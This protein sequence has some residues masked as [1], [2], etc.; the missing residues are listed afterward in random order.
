MV[1]V[2]V[3]EGVNDITDKTLGKK[4]SEIVDGSG[5][6]IKKENEVIELSSGADNK[7]TMIGENGR[8]LV[9]IAD[10]ATR[11]RAIITELANLI[12]DE[13][14]LPAKYIERT[15][16]GIFGYVVKSPV[17]VMPVGNPDAPKSLSLYD[18]GMLDLVLIFEQAEPIDE[19]EIKELEEYNEI[20]RNEN[21]K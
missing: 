17:N 11:V 18:L 14:V 2:K 3:F 7:K 4:T 20:L 6:E 5:N 21:K 16:E 13:V 15:D 9:K 1:Q 19:V 8:P 12:N 10:M